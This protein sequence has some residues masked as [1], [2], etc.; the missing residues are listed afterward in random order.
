MAYQGFYINGANLASSTAVFVDAALTIKAFDGFYSDGVNVREQSGG[1]LLTSSVCESCTSGVACD[2]ATSA[3]VVANGWFDANINLGNTATDI[4]AVVIYFYPDVTIPDGILAT[5]NGNTYN[6]LTSDGN[7]GFPYGLNSG[8]GNPTYVGG[9][10]NFTGSPYSNVP[11]YEL[12]TSGVYVDKGTTR[13]VE[14][15]SGQNDTRG[16]GTFTM[17][18]PKPSSNPETLNLQVYAPLNGTAFAW[19]VRCAAALPSFSA[20]AE[21]TTAACASATETFYFARNA[22]WNTG[23]Q[24]FDV[25]TNVRPELGNFVYSDPNGQTPISNGLAFKYYIMDNNTYIRVQYGMV[26]QTGSCS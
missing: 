14:V 16:A 6:R 24:S 8:S 5:H 20:S 11:E 13:T 15:T 17:V 7:T 9:T 19:D 12:N 18:V 26:T 2:G 23:T 10:N 1:I 21:Q 22:V 4:G 25:D 3:S